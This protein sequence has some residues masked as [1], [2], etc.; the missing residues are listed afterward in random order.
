MSKKLTVTPSAFASAGATLE[1]EVGEGM[2]KISANA[3]VK[4]GMAFP[5]TSEWVDLPGGY[6][7]YMT[8]YE[9]ENPNYDYIYKRHAYQ[10]W[11][12]SYGGASKHTGI[13]LPEKAKVVCVTRLTTKGLTDGGSASSEISI[14]LN[15]SNFQNVITDTWP[16]NV[17]DCN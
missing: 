3:D 1:V 17:S 10:Q 11:K 15:G 9:K 7:A 14:S 13:V 4:L 12:S 6:T 16:A 8:V 2:G 5:Q